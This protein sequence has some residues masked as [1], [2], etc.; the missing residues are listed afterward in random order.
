MSLK[1]WP[2][3]PNVQLAHH[4]GRVHRADRRAVVA[5]TVAD[6]EVA[7][8]LAEEAW[9]DEDV[10]EDEEAEE[11]RPASELL[12]QIGRNAS[13]VVLR[14]VQLAT[15]HRIPELRRAA[16]DAVAVVALVVAGVTA[17]VLANWAAVAALSSPLPGWRA[18]L[19]VA[20]VWAAVA[21]LLVVFVLV[22]AGR[23]FGRGWWRPLVGDPAETVRNAE[24]TR[25]EAEQAL[26]DSIEEF[27]GAVADQA[28]ALVAEAVVPLAGGALDAGEDVLD[29]VDD[30][31]DAI[32]DKVP[33]GGVI[34]QMADL[35]LMP[36][37]YVLKVVSNRVEPDDD[38]DEEDDD[39]EGAADELGR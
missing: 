5:E 34:N 36:G 37:R 16:R 29:A 21:A 7:A 32:E 17:F 25:D 26:R 13:T 38:E 24:Q 10:A 35:A 15:S 4:A 12:E 19:V 14:E 31:T 2:K 27:A 11:T 28:G 18:P 1:S 9:P 3:R 8:E 23:L 6:S 30:V 33:F 20:A 22:R 39:D